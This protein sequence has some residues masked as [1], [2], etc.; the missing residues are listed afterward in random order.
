MQNTVTLSIPASISELEAKKAEFEDAGLGGTVVASLELLLSDH[1]SFSAAVEA[2]F[3]G[4]EDEL[5]AGEAAVET[6][7]DAIE[8]GIGEFSS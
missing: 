7:H 6:I 8:A 4:S 5:G 2:R 1:D 3:T